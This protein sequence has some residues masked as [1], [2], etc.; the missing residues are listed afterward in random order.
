LV[1][2]E[3]DHVVSIPV[4]RVP[5]EIDVAGSIDEPDGF[6]FSGAVEDSRGFPR[7]RAIVE[8]ARCNQYRS[9]NVGDVVDWP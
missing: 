4:W 5:F 6:W 9:G 3:R 1:N 8:H 7:A 2:Q